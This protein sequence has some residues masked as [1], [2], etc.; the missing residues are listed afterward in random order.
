MVR[1][2]ASHPEENVREG[3]W[4]EKAFHILLQTIHLPV[5]Y[6]EPTRDWRR[7]QPVD[8]YVPCVGAIDVKSVNLQW[9]SVNIP[10]HDFYKKPDY[11]IALRR[12]PSTKYV[13]IVGMML[14]AD[15]KT[16][17]TDARGQW[18][19]NITVLTI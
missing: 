12:I 9:S 3:S 1:Y 11:F 4:A 18:N 2:G 14:A 13:L 16:L 6:P 15:V 17:C 7:L 10:T 8:F 5:N 19:L